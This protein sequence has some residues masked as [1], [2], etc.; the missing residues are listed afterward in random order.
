MNINLNTSLS[1]KN[2]HENVIANN[3]N[4]ENAIEMLLSLI[5]SS[6]N[7]DVRIECIEVF[8]NIAYNS[9]K[10]FKILENYLLS[11]V[12]PLVRATAAKAIIINFPKISFNSLLWTIEH[13]NSS[14]ILK[15]LYETFENSDKEDFDILI[16][17]LNEKLKTVY[18]IVP[19]ECKFLLDLDVQ[20]NFF[21]PNFFNIYLSNSITGVISGNYMMC[22]TENGHI[23]ALNLSNWEIS[24]LPDTIGNLSELS[25]LILKDNKLKNIPD[26]ISLLKNLET[27]ELGNCQITSLPDSFGNLKMLKKLTIERNF[28]LNSIPNAILQLAKNNISQKYI[29]NGVKPN[30]AF[31]LAVLEMLYGRELEILNNN[32]S[33]INRD[34]AWHY[35]IDKNNNITGI[36][37]FNKFIQYLGIFPEQICSLK[38][39]EEL[40][41]P[42]NA[43][44]SIPESIG[45]LINLKSLNLRNNKIEIIPLSIKKLKKLENL[46]LADNRIKEIPQWVKPLLN[47]FDLHKGLDIYEKKFFGVPF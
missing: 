31:V 9:L 44:K 37:L 35:K 17:K 3:L 11:D 15:T 36:C 33:M 29:D 26:S 16:I 23:K 5:E 32:E 30:E 46:K 4:K 24:E 40:W 27:L 21:N 12:S 7:I 10:V 22:A 41:L 8:G 2:I 18:C 1:A 13:D 45:E 38:F 47:K 42:N 34:K 25:H 6:D 20:V 43:I 28:K 39:L 19:K 14:I